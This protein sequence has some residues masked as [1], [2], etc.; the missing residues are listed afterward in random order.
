MISKVEYLRIKNEISYIS[1]EYAE[2]LDYL[3]KRELGRVIKRKRNTFIIFLS[4]MHTIIFYQSKNKLSVNIKSDLIFVDLMN[5]IDHKERFKSWMNFFNNPLTVQ[6]QKGMALV[7]LL[8]RLNALIK[9]SKSLNAIIKMAFLLKVNMQEFILLIRYFIRFEIEKILA[10]NLC[11]KV[12]PKVIALISIENY[13]GFSQGVKDWKK[14]TCLD[15]TVVTS[16]HGFFNDSHEFPEERL[17]DIHIV[18]NEH[19]KNQIIE[20]SLYES[21]P[22]MVISASLDTRISNIKILDN[23]RKFLYLSSPNIVNGIDLDKKMIKLILKYKER[24][25][26]L[27]LDLRIRLHPG[28]QKINYPFIDSLLIE[29]SLS[30]PLKV[31]LGAAKFSIAIHGSS[32][33]TAA[34]Q[35]VR[36]FILI[37]FNSKQKI[38]PGIEQISQESIESG[39]FINYLESNSG[40]LSDIDTMIEFCYGDPNLQVIYKDIILNNMNI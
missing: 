19:Y 14:K 26:E 36:C 39:E 3:I 31:S 37:P 15:I 6:D 28:M 35:G 8:D 25:D 13:R 34:I 10:V 5:R 23:A 40:N 29:D 32:I 18:W 30:L 11:N 17:S 16:Q 20:K 24:F 27:G 38:I 4:I 9:F 2:T 7:S 1:E 33:I 22:N 21:P 12:Q